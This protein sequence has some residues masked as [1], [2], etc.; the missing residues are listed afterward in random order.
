MSVAI[1]PA[2]LPQDYARIA[3]VLA[4]E[5]PGWAA[6]AEE[7]AHED[8][9]RDPRYYHATFVAEELDV[10][11]PLMVGV[12]F[13]G[14]DIMAHQDGRFEINLRVREAWQG[15]RVGK[16]LYDAI[17]AHLVPLG[18]RELCATVWQAHPRTARFLT[19]RGFVEAWLWI[20][21]RLDTTSFDITPYDGLEQRLSDTAIAIS[22]RSAV[23]SYL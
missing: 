10:A 19:E 1:R 9:E 14:H 12:G 2:R 20:D 5:S 4:D 11:E 6:S 15:R 3:D 21:S 22:A 13:V 8:A 7:L 17:L 16:A 18:P 23:E